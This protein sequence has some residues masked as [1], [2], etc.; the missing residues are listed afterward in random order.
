MKAKHPTGYS[1]PA[2]VLLF[3]CT[4]VECFTLNQLYGKYDSLAFSFKP[5]AKIPFFSE[6]NQKFTIF[7]L[8][9]H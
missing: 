2:S 7:L 5:L 8:L 3:H 9:I 1:Y 6:A 4:L